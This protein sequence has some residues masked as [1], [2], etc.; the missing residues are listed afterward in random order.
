M[1]GIGTKKKMMEENLIIKKSSKR[2]GVS[3]STQKSL[4]VLF[5]YEA[6]FIKEGYVNFFV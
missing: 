6:L 5:L 1:Y 2:S 3:V 4:Q